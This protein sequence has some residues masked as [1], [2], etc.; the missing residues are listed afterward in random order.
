VLPLCVPLLITSV[1]KIEGS[2]IAAELRGFHLR[3]KKSCYKKYVV[4]INDICVIMFSVV[5]VGSAILVNNV[6]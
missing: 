1:R 4:N 6:F 3:T 2:A 5:I